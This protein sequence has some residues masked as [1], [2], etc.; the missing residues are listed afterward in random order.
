MDKLP[1]EVK[2]IVNLYVGF[3]PKNK[4]ELEEAVELYITNK[5][6]AIKLYGNISKWDTILITDMSELF[7][8]NYEFNENINNWN[9]SNVKDMSYMFER[10][11]YFRGFLDNWDVQNVE[12]M[13][14]M[15]ESARYFNGDIGNWNVGNVKTMKK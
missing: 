4:K 15:F 2:D 7:Y 12:N 8:Q 9:V 3:V 6:E 1:D 11:Y 13:E 5:E 10:V 14:G